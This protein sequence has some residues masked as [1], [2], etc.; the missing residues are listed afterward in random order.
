MNKQTEANRKQRDL[1]N[2]Y[3][4]LKYQQILKCLIESQQCKFTFNEK[5]VRIKTEFT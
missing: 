2:F 5:H 4:K 3:F 1:V